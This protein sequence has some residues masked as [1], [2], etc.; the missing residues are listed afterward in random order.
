MENTCIK[1]GELDHVEYKG[2]YFFTI[3]ASS[4]HEQVIDNKYGLK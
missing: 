3:S 1:A 4:C 2:Q